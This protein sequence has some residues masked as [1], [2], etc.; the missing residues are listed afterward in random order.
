MPH[1]YISLTLDEAAQLHH[2]IERYQYPLITSPPLPPP[3]NSAGAAWHQLSLPW[4][5]HTQSREGYTTYKLIVSS[6]DLATLP[7]HISAY[8][9]N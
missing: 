2:S 5:R 7:P 1:T 6:Q 8:F 4:G 3:S 9:H